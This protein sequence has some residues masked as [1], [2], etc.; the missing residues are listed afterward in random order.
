[1]TA[2]LQASGTK[3]LVLLRTTSEAGHGFGTAL[4]E[5]IAQKADVMAFLLDQ[6]GIPGSG[7]NR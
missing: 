3:R 1:M 4:S 2:R 7:S 6:W 5:Q